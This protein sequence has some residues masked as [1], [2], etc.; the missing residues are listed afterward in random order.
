MDKTGTAY[1][2]T[3]IKAGVHLNLNAILRGLKKE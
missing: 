2:E 3:C 1:S